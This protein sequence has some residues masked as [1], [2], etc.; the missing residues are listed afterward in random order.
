MHGQN[1]IKSSQGMFIVLRVKGFSWFSNESFEGTAHLLWVLLHIRENCIVKAWNGPN[2]CLWLCRV[3]CT[4]FCLGFS[5]EIWGN[6]GWRSPAFTI[7]KPLHGSDRRKFG[8]SLQILQGRRTKYHCVVRSKL[9][10]VEWNIPVKSWCGS[11]PCL[12][13]HCSP[14]NRSKNLYLMKLGT[15]EGPVDSHLPKG[16]EEK[17]N[18]SQDIGCSV[19]HLNCAP[20]DCTAQTLPEG[21]T[22][23]VPRILKADS[24]IACSAHAVPLRV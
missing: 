15:A 20:F 9:G 17:R 6:F 18:K 19:L 1:H 24:H 16:T 21:R 23:W 3:E 5:I 2:S 22:F 12:F 10:P 8:E 13:L 7:R 14:T 4:G 11:S